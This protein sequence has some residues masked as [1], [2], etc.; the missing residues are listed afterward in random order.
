VKLVMTLLVRN[1]EDIVGEH[2]RYHLE[3]GAVDFV[4]A[5]DHR[6][7]DGTTDIL[8]S[9][10]RDGHLHLIR[11]EGE[12]FLQ[13]EYVTRM[14]RLAASDFG[15]DWVINSDADEFWWPREASLREILAAVPP[16]FGLVIGLWRHF[17][18]RPEDGRPFYER[19]TWRR[20]PELDLESPYHFNIKVAHRGDPQV[21]VMQGNHKAWG[22]GL[23][24]LREW[25]PIE[26]LH[27][28]IRTRAQLER[29]FT[30]G[31][32]HRMRGYHWERAARTIR[33]GGADALHD[34]WLVD[35]DVL[36]A[37]I[38]A[39]ALTED[40]RLRDAL[41]AGSVV[42]A[43]GG[44]APSIAEQAAFAAEVSRSE[45]A[46]PH[47][48]L[49]LRARELRERVDTLQRSPLLRRSSL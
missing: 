31:A 28:P 21:N 48:R 40:L 29:K 46:E 5:T 47:S 25:I 37:A 45:H 15:A 1:E 49:W 8:R 34:T 44:E 33:G 9:Y 27:F 19:M 12:A 17:V 36:E 38:A 39:G 42:A 24:F 22:R 43:R 11:E 10:E 7:T 13:P 20:R 2:L 14:A 6:S 26:V 3:Q 18:M 32:T 4:V 41:R 35:D 30:T 23:V 16:R